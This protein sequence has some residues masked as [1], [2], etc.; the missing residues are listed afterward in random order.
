M[1]LCSSTNIKMVANPLGDRK[2]RP[3]PQTKDALKTM[4][5]NYCKGKMSYGEPNTW[6]VTLVTDMSMLFM[7]MKT[8]NAPIDQ[9]NTSE[10]TKMNGM[11]IGAKSFNQAITMDTSQVTNMSFMFRWASSFNQPITMDTSKVTK[12]NGM[13]CGASSF[14]QPITMDTSQ[15]I[16]MSC[17]FSGAKSFNQPITMDTSKV[18]N[19]F[20]MFEGADAMTHAHPIRLNV[21]IIYE[22]RATII[23]IF[24]F[25]V[26]FSI[27][28]IFFLLMP[29]LF[30]SLGIGMLFLLFLS[31]IF[32]LV[33]RSHKRR[34]S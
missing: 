31:S 9:W 13:F 27:I 7:D 4:I 8:F 32:S 19:M 10:V 21:L 26:L 11:F 12:M 20:G 29:P 30:L 14:N 24:L 23:F 25:F 18:T 22:R 15:V 2:K 1:G 28:D 34:R 17:M 16:N 6:D 33:F 3:Q 5:E